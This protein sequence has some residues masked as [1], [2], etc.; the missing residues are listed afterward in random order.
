MFRMNGIP[1]RHLVL[2]MHRYMDVTYLSDAVRRSA[3]AIAE[4]QFKTHSN[5]HF[6]LKL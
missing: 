4:E 3:V 5:N 1:Q 2:K 6:L